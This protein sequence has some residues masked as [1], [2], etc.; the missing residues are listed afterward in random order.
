MCSALCHSNTSEQIFIDCKMTAKTF[1][2]PFRHSECQQF[3]HTKGFG[4]WKGRF[5][6]QKDGLVH[7]DFANN[8][9]M[10]HVL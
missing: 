8:R 3:F 6:T 2:I 10:C 5:F 7:F 9:Y 1:A 4:M